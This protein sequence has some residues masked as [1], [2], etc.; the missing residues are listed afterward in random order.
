[1]CGTRYMM[2]NLVDKM[3]DLVDKMHEH[4]SVGRIMYLVSC[5][6]CHVHPHTIVHRE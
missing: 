6:M 5:I 3:C 4:V 2:Y 1:M